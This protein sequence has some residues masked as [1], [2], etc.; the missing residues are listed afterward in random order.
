VLTPPELQ[1]E[2]LARLSRYDRNFERRAGKVVKVV[3]VTAPDDV[4]STTSAAAMRTA[5]SRVDLIGGLP[6]EE[7]VVV[8]KSSKELADLVRTQRVAIVYLTPGFHDR[9]PELRAAL[10]GSDVL[11]VAALPEYVPRGIV[12]GFEVVSGRTK[13]TLNLTQAKLQNVSL[14]ADVIKLMKVFK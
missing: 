4:R 12:L 7:S 2:L 11:T 8:F 13:M 14:K 10:T 1:A 5:L 3:I 9:V 6:H